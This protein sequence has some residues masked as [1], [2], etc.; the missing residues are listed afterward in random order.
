MKR[1]DSTAKANG[2][3]GRRAGSG[4][5]KQE[6]IVE[7]ATRRD[8]LLEVFTAAEWR[9]IA[10]LLLAEAKDGS[11]MILLPYLPYLLGS[12]KQ[13]INVTGQIEHVQM[14]TARS[15]LRVVGGTKAS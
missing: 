12:P 3:G 2:H 11:L 10:R 7:Q 1:L 13:E 6:T 9:T 14:E 8:I 15:V 5:K 4:R